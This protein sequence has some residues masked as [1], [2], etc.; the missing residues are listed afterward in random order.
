M[1]TGGWGLGTDTC[2]VLRALTWLLP[3]IADDLE[4][5]HGEQ[6]IQRHGPQTSLARQEPCQCGLFNSGPPRY[7]IARQFRLRK[8]PAHFVS[9]GAFGLARGH[10]PPRSLF[11]A[12]QDV[13]NMQDEKRILDGGCVSRAH[14]PSAIRQD[15]SGSHDRPN[16][17]RD[18]IHGAI[19]PTG[20][21]RYLHGKARLR[22]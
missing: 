11:I 21:I 16:L 1:V 10:N 3:A 8:C 5:Q 15:W 2:S 22:F 12:T 4:S 6:A 19:M 20:R 7:L 14:P 17:V 18:T 13:R 9:D